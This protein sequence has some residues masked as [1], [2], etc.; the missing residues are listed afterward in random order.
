[1]TLAPNA[2]SIE[3]YFGVCVKYVEDHS[4]ARVEGQDLELVEFNPSVAIENGPGDEETMPLDGRATT[5]SKEDD[6]AGAA[7][8]SNHDEGA[9]A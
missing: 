4:R 8:G 6:D 5:P 9:N 2:F 3:G 7:K 1:L